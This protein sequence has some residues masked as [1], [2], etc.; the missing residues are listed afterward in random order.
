MKLTV[1]L[2]LDAG[3]PLKVAVNAVTSCDNLPKLGQKV[4]VEE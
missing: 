3:L 2:A 1:K 4:S